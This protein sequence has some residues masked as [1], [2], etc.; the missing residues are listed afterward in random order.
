MSISGKSAKQTYPDKSQANHP[1]SRKMASLELGRN[2]P[3]MVSS[4]TAIKNVTGPRESPLWQGKG[5]W[6]GEES[7]QTDLQTNH[8]TRHGIEHHRIERL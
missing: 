5:T 6:S 2:A 7:L 8:T 3:I 4:C 1:R